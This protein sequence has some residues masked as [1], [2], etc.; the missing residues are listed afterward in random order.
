MQVTSMIEI[1]RQRLFI[2]HD[3][4]EQ[5]SI[6]SEY[7]IKSKREKLTN[8]IIL[9]DKFLP[10]LLVRDEDDSILPVMTTRDVK[11]L[12]SH[13]IEKS[14]NETQEKLEHLNSKINAEELHMI[15]IKIPK[16]KSL[17]KDEVRTFTLNYSPHHI[18]PPRSVLKMKIKKQP[19]PLYYTLFTPNEFDFAQT[20]YGFIKDGKIKQSYHQPEYVQKFRTY[21]SNLFRII[22]HIEDGFKISYSF[23]PT[24]TSTAPTKIGLFT[25]AGLSLAIVTFKYIVYLGDPPDDGI[26][27]KQLEIGLFVI[28][29]SLLLPQLT[30]NYSIRARYTWW[31]LLPIGLGIG[32]LI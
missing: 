22:S 25:L 7:T 24:R 3:H 14:S 9:S 10:N 28:G 11:K 5:R 1:L 30:N 16:N 29:G 18:D 21:N 2:S 4:K 26:F 32:I 27:A 13:F 15:W 20:R 17:Y 19:Y 31:Y 12:I 6:V 23:K 8:I